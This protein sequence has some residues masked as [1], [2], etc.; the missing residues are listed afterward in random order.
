MNN[1][2]NYIK[3]KYISEIL[4][5][6][7]FILTIIFLSNVTLLGNLPPILLY[8]FM[9]GIGILLIIIFS[10]K[11]E[12]FLK[13]KLF[14]LF[15]SLYLIYTLIQHYILISFFPN[16]APY[17]FEDERRFYEYSNLGLPYITGEKN[18]FDLFSIYEIHQ[19]PLHIVF[20]AS[21]TY[22]STLI[23][24]SNSILLQKLLSPFF[25]GLFI[26]VLYS[27]LKY[28]FK[29]SSFSLKAT[30]TYGLLSAVFMYSIPLLR[31][32]DVALAYIIFF[33]L[34]LQKNS[35][36]NFLLLFL[37]AFMTYFLR[38]ESGMVLYALILLYSYL[39]VRTIKSTLIKFIFYILILLLFAFVVIFLYHKIIGMVVGLDEA[40]T[41]RAVAKASADSISLLFNKLP[42]PLSYLAKV[43]FGQMQ[44]FP[45]LHAIDRPMEAISGLFWPFIFI[46]M[47]Y[48]IVKKEIRVLINEKIK[49]LLIIAILV[50][51]LMS[52]E[53]MAR[54]MM[55]VYPII[56][57]T[58]LYAFTVLPNT[59][60]K[61]F[62]SYYL[63]AII[64]LN[65]FYYV[66]KL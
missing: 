45:F 11:N 62:F 51:F 23:D 57:F 8:F 18:F 46:M 60:I 35:F 14:I 28:Q 54:R 26:V 24:G 34:F 50:L 27:T 32:I 55:S 10:N 44:P 15:F 42:F 9:L 1:L 56:Y 63:F 4:T 19:L 59:K 13:I 36:F 41:M 58:S 7:L 16:S 30:I 22:F 6:I 65:I 47:L 25:G 33:Y 20:S 39:N 66:I 49:Y 48:A 21:I 3:N 2:L 5:I 31:D 52:S 17:N 40:N 64:S 29:D 43:L 38:V 61:R 12:I 53:P 37:V